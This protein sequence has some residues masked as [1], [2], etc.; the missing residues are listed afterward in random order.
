M[1]K[2]AVA[3]LVLAGGRG[4]RL[5]LAGIAAGVAVGVTL[6]LTLWAGFNALTARA[7]RSSW[8]MMQAGEP[9]GGASNIKLSADQLIASPQT[10]HFDGQLI[11]RGRHRRH[12][13]LARSRA[14]DERNTEAR[15]ILCVTR[16][17]EAHRFRPV[18][19]AG[20]QI[21]NTG[22]YDLR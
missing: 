6:I 14:R 20:E 12:V 7:E 22:R 4:S 5:R 16:A 17:C 8:T 21:R 15:H 3:R 18:Q 10:D 19:L 9:I 2:F 13:G 1:P 11:T